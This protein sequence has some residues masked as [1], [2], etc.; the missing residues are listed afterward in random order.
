M[1]FLFEGAS[2]SHSTHHEGHDQNQRMVEDTIVNL[3]NE[4][5]EE[6]SSL[7]DIN[8]RTQ[9]LVERIHTRRSNNLKEI[10][11][12]QKVLV[13]KVTEVCQQMKQKLYKAYEE[14]SSEMGLKLQELTDVLEMCTKLHGE[15]LEAS[16]VLGGLRDGLAVSGVAEPVTD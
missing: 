2:A 8:R 3:N 12:F 7:N 6:N 9:E 13:D 1:D 5:I 15:L 11:S 16:H 10:E 14:N 4:N